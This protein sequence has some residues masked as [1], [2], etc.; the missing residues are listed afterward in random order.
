[1]KKITVVYNDRWQSG[2][3]WHCLTKHKRLELNENE[4]V[5]TQVVAAVV[6]ED[7]VFIFEGWPKHLGEEV[8]IL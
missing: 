7:V 8:D 6:S 5:M 4:P 3:H 2:S 1:M